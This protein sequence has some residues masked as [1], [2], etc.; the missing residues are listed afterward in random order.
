M[1]KDKPR[2]ETVRP[3]EH[4]IGRKLQVVDGSRVYESINNTGDVYS[5]VDV[6]LCGNPQ[7][8]CITVWNDDTGQVVENIDAGEAFISYQSG[9]PIFNLI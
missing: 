3:N 6:S 5:I 4:L 2:T 7:V 9:K 1:D 8:P